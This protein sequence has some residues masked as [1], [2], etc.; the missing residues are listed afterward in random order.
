[1]Q[2]YNIWVFLKPYYLFG[3]ET[4]NI[5]PFANLVILSLAFLPLCVLETWDIGRR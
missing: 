1:M 5:S 2:E 4:F 3:P